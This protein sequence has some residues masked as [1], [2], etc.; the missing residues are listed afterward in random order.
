MDNPLRSEAA[1]FRLVVLVGLAAVPVV[2]LGLLAG[3]TWALVAIV[4][5]LAAAVFLVRR[6]RGRAQPPPPTCSSR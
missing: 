4:L 6:G 3:A 1:M 2:A 5:E